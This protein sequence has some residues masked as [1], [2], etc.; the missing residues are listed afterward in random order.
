MRKTNF[1]N[2][3]FITAL[4]I[5]SCSKNDTPQVVNEEEVITTL[6]VILTPAGGGTA[7][8]LQSQ[9]LDADGPNA[10]D[11]TV[12]GPLSAGVVYNGSIA[13]LNE[14]ETPPGNVTEEVEQESNEHQFFYTV[15][16]L[17]ITTAY[18]NFDGNGNPLGTMFTLTTGVA[19]TGTLTFTLRHEPTKPN[20]GLSDAG[21]ETDITVTFDVTIQ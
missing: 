15:A 19:G 1:L 7:I 11:V 14:T 4:L 21:G 6:T 10:P 2:V 8:T 13:L 20:T 18:T 5:V 17:D 3:L 16:G 12:S 9:D